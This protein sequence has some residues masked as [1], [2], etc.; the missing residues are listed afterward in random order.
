MKMITMMLN[1]ML[2]AMVAMVTGMENEAARKYYIQV[3]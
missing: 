3:A 2:V 1:V